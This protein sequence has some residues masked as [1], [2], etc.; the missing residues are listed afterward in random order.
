MKLKQVCPRC[1]T[2]TG[3]TMEKCPDGKT[4]CG[5]CG[6][7]A[8]HLNFYVRLPEEVIERVTKDIL[9]NYLYGKI[10]EVRESMTGGENHFELMEKYE[11]IE[12]V[13]RLIKYVQEIIL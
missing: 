9:I 11:E 12:L 7:T 3:F 6:Y 13:D 2:T 1:L 10:L 5:T 4:I 8:L